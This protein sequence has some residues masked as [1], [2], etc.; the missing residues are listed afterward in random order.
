MAAGHDHSSD[1]WGNYGGLNLSMGRKSGYG[2][3]GPKFKNVGARVFDLT[4]DQKTG[5]MTINTWI[6]EDDGS[7]DQ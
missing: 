7:I 6:R 2:S 4:V 5:N 3:F 1:Y